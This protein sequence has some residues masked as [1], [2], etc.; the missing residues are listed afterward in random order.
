MCFVF[1]FS[2]F[3]FVRIFQLRI[4]SCIVL[5]CCVS[6]VF[7][8][9]AGK[10]STVCV[11]VPVLVVWKMS[12]DRNTQ[13]I[14]RFNVSSTISNGKVEIIFFFHIYSTLS[15]RVC[16]DDR[17]GLDLHCARDHAA[18]ALVFMSITIDVSLRLWSLSCAEEKRQESK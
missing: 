7:G 9:F 4:H 11:G 16:I 18:F 12:E 2:S 13:H 8:M 3:F 15:K 17:S 6:C 10:S 1:L 5:S 14:V